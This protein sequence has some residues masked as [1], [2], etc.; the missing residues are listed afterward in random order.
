MSTNKNVLRS[1]DELLADYTPSHKPLISEFLGNSQGYSQDVG[2]VNFKRLQ[3]VGDVEAKFISPKDTVF[4]EVQV[5]EGLKTFKKAFFGTQFVQSSLQ[6]RGQVEDVSKQVLDVLNKQ[7]DGFLMGDGVNSGI[8]TS[9]DAN[10]VSKNSAQ[11]TKANDQHIDAIHSKVVS[12]AMEADLLAGPKLILFYG[13]NILNE[14]NMLYANTSAPF[15]TALANVLGSEYSLGVIPSTITTNDEGF[16]I[17]S[18]DH[19][20]LHYTTLPTIVAQGEDQRAMEIWQNFLL[21]SCMVD[22]KTKGAII[23]QPLTLA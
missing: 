7:M 11:M 5:N 22:L 14:Y 17:I 16:L 12:L 8:Y 20:K 21:G 2:A 9:T 4:Q 23:K 6:D 13:A 18:R 15:K 10:Y 3:V 1:V 19:A